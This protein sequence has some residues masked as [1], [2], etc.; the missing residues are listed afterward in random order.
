M[1]EKIHVYSTATH[2]FSVCVYDQLPLIM[3]AGSVK[4]NPRFNQLAVKKRIKINGGA[5]VAMRDNNGVNTRNIV[6]TVLSREDF[7]LVR[8]DSTFRQLFANGLITF[9]KS[10]EKKEKVLKDLVERDE[11]SP[12]TP[13]RLKKINQ[14]KG[15]SIIDTEKA[16]VPLELT[17]EVIRNYK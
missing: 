15:A 12:I 11:F 8:K 13:E 9:S 6:E 2:S 1:S 4:H 17:N 16:P 3:E 14:T 10:G 5:N 7:D